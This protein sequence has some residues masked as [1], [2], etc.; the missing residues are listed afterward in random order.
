MNF[1]GINKEAK[2]R[3]RLQRLLLFFFF[4]IKST[5]DTCL[6]RKSNKFKLICFHAKNKKKKE[7]MR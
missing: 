2:S 7:I 6:I 4:F 3:H 1:V 5:H